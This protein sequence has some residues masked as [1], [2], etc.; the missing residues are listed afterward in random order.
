MG[1]CVLSAI[2]CHACHCEARGTE[3]ICRAHCFGAV[4]LEV[5]EREAI[6]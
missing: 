1:I 5:T 6:S 4:R 2:G 3:A